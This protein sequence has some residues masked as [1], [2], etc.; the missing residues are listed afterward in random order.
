MNEICSLKAGGAY[1]S[2]KVH[3]GIKSNVNAPVKVIARIIY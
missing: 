3:N 2:I 1:D